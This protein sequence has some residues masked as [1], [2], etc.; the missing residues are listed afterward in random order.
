M[1]SGAFLPCEASL[2]CA[3]ALA[4]LTESAG[5]AESP[6]GMSR[7]T[8]HLACQA[9]PS[10]PCEASLTCTA[11]LACL[12]KSAGHAESPNGMFRRTR[13]QA[14]LHRRMLLG[15][16]R[17]AGAA[18]PLWFSG[19]GFVL[20]PRRSTCSPRAR[21]CRLRVCRAAALVRR[22]VL[23]G[24]EDG[25]TPRT[26]A[27]AS[28]R[29]RCQQGSQRRSQLW[30]LCRQP[31]GASDS[32]SQ[33]ETVAANSLAAPH[34]ALVHPAA[35]LTRTL[36]RHID[37][38][39]ANPYP[40]LR[41]CSNLKTKRFNAPARSVCLSRWLG[42]SSNC[43]RDSLQRR[44]THLEVHLGLRSQ[45]DG[46]AHEA[47]LGE[48]PHLRGRGFTCVARTLR[49]RVRTRHRRGWTVARQR[50]SNTS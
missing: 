28:E 23:P 8:A 50:K 19:G 34:V 22:P 17:P 30:A 40:S 43:G 3:A 49:S 46:T 45:L 25:A 21:T 12:T 13:Q 39:S 6:N 31:A 18:P 20:A 38:Y 47:Q 2:T 32:P 36:R 9:A 4:C 1:S 44:G 5:H 16:R 42:Q 37:S 27:V 48:A 10:C 35:A 11:A 41:Q 7:R 24:C 29:A 33:A 26:A 15:P 14:R